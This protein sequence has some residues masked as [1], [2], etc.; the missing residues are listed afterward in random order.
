MLE[1]ERSG[2]EIAVVGLAGRF[3]GAEDVPALWRNLRDGVDA[4]HDFTEAELLRLGIGEELLADPCHVRAGGYLPG[5]EDF[6]ADLFGLDAEEAART[7]PQ[8]RLFLEQAW[9]ALEDA[10]YDPARDRGTI[11][12]FA[13]ASV[14]RYFLFHLL[15]NPAVSAAGPD[16]WEGRLVPGAAP[17]YLPAQVAY[18]LGLTGPAV[19]VQTACSSSLVAVCL[20]AQSLADFR[21]DL[22][23]A[24]GVS[25]TWPRHRYT[26]GGLVSQDGR[27]R[28]FDAAGQG[29][30][31]GSG[32]GVVV[33]KRVADADR[34]TVHAVVRGWAVN[35]DGAVRAGFAAPG[36]D[37]QAAVVVEALAGAAVAPEE[38]GYVEAHGSGTLVGD[39]IEVAALTRAFRA[40]SDRPAAGRVGSCALGSVKTNLGNLD[41]AAGV[42]GLIKA[43][44]AVRHG[45]I[46]AH[47]HYQQPNPE[48][49]FPAT[50]FFVPTKTLDWPATPR[51]AGVS[52]FGLGGTNAHVIVEQPPATRPRGRGGGWHVLPLSARS[53][54]HLREVAARLR[55]YLAATPGV[56]LGDV[57]Y[58]L[59]VGR[60]AFGHRAAVVCEDVAGAVA[61]LDPARFDPTRPDP[62]VV[63][64]APAGPVPT[65]ADPHAH[66]DADADAVAAL[67]RS[68]SAGEQVDWGRVHAGGASRRVPLPTYPFAR[69]RYWIDPPARGASPAPAAG[70][71]GSP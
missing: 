33:L 31:F 11:G 3:P 2:D 25:V 9:V 27:C 66:A 60:R 50:P 14:N 55:E 15:G 22:A 54:D 62:V 19:A 17:D 12:V 30:A 70:E 46:P 43:A 29:A 28:A 7:D 26:P 38:I 8:H 68:W 41:A 5:V 36:V 18:R 56:V 52:S 67:G 35:N 48:I 24:G 65:D 40:A 13:G 42:T 32:V 59:A 49:D 47:L 44:L 57:A 4:V 6:D 45:T 21:C 37:G 71:E 34:D 20:A 16:D 51:I 64:A 39:A 58:T 23:L 53:R 69:R 63:G 61:A 1:I 10:G